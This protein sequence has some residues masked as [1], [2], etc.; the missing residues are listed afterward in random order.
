MQLPPF[1][2]EWEAESPAQRRS[3]V[4]LVQLTEQEPVH[5]MWQVELP[6]H[7]TLA[8][9]PTVAV[10]AEFPVQS[11]LHESRHAP[12]QVVWFEHEREQLPASPPQLFAVNAQLPPE[13]QEHDAPPQVGGGLE[14]ELA[15]SSVA[16]MIK[17]T[18]IRGRIAMIFTLPSTR[19][20]P[21]CSAD[22][23]PAY[24]GL[25]ALR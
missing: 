13:L 9:F 16:A 18:R 2:M 20:A 12:A 6:L 7:E 11:T 10:H 22:R 24:R 8:L 15:Q 14:P 3:H 25:P 1:G 23:S 4:A 19:P 17:R 21:R 5:V